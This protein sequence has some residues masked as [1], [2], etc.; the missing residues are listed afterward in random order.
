MILVC[1]EAN[2]LFKVLKNSGFHISR[3]ED[4]RKALEISSAG[5]SI[6][7]LADEYPCNGVIIDNEALEMVRDKSLRVYIEYPKSLPSIKVGEPREVRW[8]RVVVSSKF[9]QPSLEEYSILTLHNAWFLPIYDSLNE[10]HLVL[11]KVA[12]YKK[13]ICGPPQEV[14]PLLF[15]LP[16][17]N[18]LVA[19][20]KLGQFITGRY[21]PKESW[22]RL[23]QGI[24]RW[25]SN[26]DDIL[27]FNWEPTVTTMA[28]LEEV[29]PE[30]FELKAFNRSI[31][32]FRNNIVY[33]IDWKKGS[34]EGF[35]SGIDYKGRQMRR[36]VV[37]ADC[38]AETAMV[39]AYDWII[40]RN[41]ESKKLS[42]EILNYVWSSDFF[43]NVPDTPVYGLVSWGEKNPVFYGD[44]NARVIL[45]S[46]KVSFLLED[47]SWIEYILK[48]ILANFRLTGPLGFRKA[49]FD[50]PDSFLEAHNRQYYHNK[51]IIHYS[52]HYQAYLWACYL[53]L[54]K[55][56]RYEEFF[57]KTENAIRMTM[58]VYPDKWR[59]TNGLTQEM[60]RI[61]LPLVALIMCRDAPEY[62]RWL[63]KI[64]DDL[65]LQME[66]CGAIREKVGLLEYG[67]YPPPR[68]N[69]E[70]GIREA[71][72]I[73]E[74]GDPICD[75]L[76]TVNY[77]FLGLHEAAIV[78]G[79][80]K[81]KVAE[82]RL[83][84]FLCRIQVKSNTHTYLDGCW[85][86]GFDYNLWEYY[87][88][89]A[90]IGWGVWSVESGWTNSWI[91]S[92]LAMRYLNEPFFDLKLSGEIEDVFSR[93]LKEML[94]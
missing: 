68:S 74:N 40:N 7:I 71:P 6:L 57:K 3:S 36:I 15:K 20:S 83:A 72:L 70:Y 87:G 64:I 21:A 44:D 16:E 54:Y 38:L 61:L 17:Y 65:L 35:E 58:E 85:M 76:Y 34:I 63:N 48:S 42:K 4:P 5:E 51:E 23:W 33:S 50:Y 77:A 31:E 2:D 46:L 14:F 93:L 53:W 28:G 27:E 90:D 41:P 47:V 45:S 79:D 91:S 49:R 9:F 75:L 84:E 25:I 26:S 13:A 29:L 86:R 12:G 80:K 59:W 39:F 24:L 60:A 30:N 82:D 56:T 19:T 62:R 66:P 22:K 43:Y 92:V 10:L 8:E 89:S 18:I 78:T 1:K 37:R 94:G 55:L 81:I 32:W 69:E 11:A 88:T 73:Q 67:D 52:P